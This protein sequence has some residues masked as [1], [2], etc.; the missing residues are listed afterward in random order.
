MTNEADPRIRVLEMLAEGK[1]TSQEAT[2]LLGALNPVPPW[3][4]TATGEGRARRHGRTRERDRGQESTGRS[5]FRIRVDPRVEAG[6][7][8][9]A[10]RVN[11]RI[12]I[13]LVKAG[14]RL[15]SLIPG[16]AADRVNEMLEAR[17]IDLDFKNLDVDRLEEILADGDFMIDI[18][19]GEW[20]I[21]ISV[22]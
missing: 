13:G 4:G 21:R 1:I 20:R 9:H 22:D 12:P 8:P 2:G 3:A 17:G 7:D 14:V 16:P 18:T 6:A 5:Y 15:T 19:E 11:I 10:D